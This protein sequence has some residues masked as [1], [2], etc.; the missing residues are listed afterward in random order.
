MTSGII[1]ILAAL[2][3]F[4]IKV[5]TDKLAAD[6]TQLSEETTQDENINKAIVNHSNNDVAVMLNDMLTR[7]QDQSG[8]N[9]Q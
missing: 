1:V 5:I 3:P 9:K 4:V 8:S 6:N 7:L 2:I